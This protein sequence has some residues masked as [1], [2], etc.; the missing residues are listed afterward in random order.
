MD[1]KSESILERVH[2]PIEEMIKLLGRNGEHWRRG[3]STPTARGLTIVEALR[4]CQGKVGDA[5]IIEQVANRQGWGQQGRQAD[6]STSFDD[7]V[8]IMSLA[9]PLGP[10]DLS[11]TFGP[12]WWAV[13]SIIR[14]VARL[15]DE[16]LD[17]LAQLCTD[18]GRA[19]Q[20]EQAATAAVLVST[21]RSRTR[22]LHRGVQA[23][24]ESL[25]TSAPEVTMAPVSAVVAASS[26]DLRGEI[27]KTTHH[28]L[29]MGPWIMAGHTMLGHEWPVSDR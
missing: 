11:E 22:T 2:I 17:D 24:F 26:F 21:F 13:V 8:V 12:M 15:D 16:Q 14:Q 10:D 9:T 18:S 7:L 23:V 4:E 1:I 27:Y 29:L 19:R 6:P 20:M 28:E 5:V 25:V 3:P